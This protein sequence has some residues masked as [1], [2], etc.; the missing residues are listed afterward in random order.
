MYVNRILHLSLTFSYFLI[1]PALLAR[2]KFFPTFGKFLDITYNFHAVGKNNKKILK[3]LP[4]T[5]TNH[6]PAYE[7]K[8]QSLN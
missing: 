1:W 5:I 3:I 4:Q 7:T 8:M 2:T 6:I